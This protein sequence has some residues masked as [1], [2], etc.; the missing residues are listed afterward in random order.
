MTEPLPPHDMDQREK[1][2]QQDVMLVLIAA[3]SLLNGMQASPFLVIF[4]AGLAPILSAFFI[5][6]PVLLFYFASLCAGVSTVILAGIPAA[7]Y[8]RFAGGGMTSVTSLTIW[9]AGSVI[10]AIPT[11]LRFFQAA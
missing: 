6:S 8:E 9:L 4:A 1:T 11:I 10:L 7:L 5:T 3:I 2:M